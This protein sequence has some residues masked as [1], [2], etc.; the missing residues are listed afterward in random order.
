[1]KKIKEKTINPE[2]AWGIVYKGEITI[3]LYKTKSE[4]NRRK[5]TLTGKSDDGFNFARKIYDKK[6]MKVV[7]VEIR[8]IK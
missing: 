8:V 4:A 2:K 5:V 6:D 7:Q 3:P 1:M